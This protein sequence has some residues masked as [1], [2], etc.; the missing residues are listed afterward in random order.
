MTGLILSSLKDEFTAM[1]PVMKTYI[2]AAVKSSIKAEQVS[3]VVEEANKQITKSWAEVAS[4]KQKQLITDVVKLTS[5]AAL[6][7]SMQLVDASLTEQ[8]KRSMNVIVSGL[9]ETGLNPSK[10][11]LADSFVGLMDGEIDK[12]DIMMARRLGVFSADKKTQRGEVA[13]RNVLITLRYEGDAVYA[14]N[15]GRGRKIVMDSQTGKAVW[16]NPDLT[17]LERDARLNARKERQQKRRE[18]DDRQKT[19]D[20]STVGASSDNAPKN[21]D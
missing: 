13:V 6:T 15:T 5:Q 7:E 18:E 8:K 17:K 10:E 3:G 20:E 19:T 14:H 9:P 16:I 4:G 1:Y 12:R 2:E 11:E 21:V